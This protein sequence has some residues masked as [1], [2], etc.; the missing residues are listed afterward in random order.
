MV[1]QPHRARGCPELWQ[2]ARTFLMRNFDQVAQIS[3]EI[4]TTSAED[5]VS[6]IGDD[7]LNSKDE[8]SVWQC[9]VRWIDHRPQERL[10][11]LRLL[12]GN[13]RLGLMAPKVGARMQ[14]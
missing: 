3:Q 6:I 5:F 13:V 11:Q 10:P 14:I 7:D 12:M 8:E 9:C 4:L 2:K 1:Y